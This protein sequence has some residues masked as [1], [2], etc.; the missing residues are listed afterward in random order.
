MSSSKWESSYYGKGNKIIDNHPY[1]NVPY[2]IDIETPQH[3]TSLWYYDKQKLLKM[4]L[5]DQ[6]SD[7]DVLVKNARIIKQ[8][9]AFSESNMIVLDKNSMEKAIDR[10]EGRELYPLYLEYK[11][12]IVQSKIL[13]KIRD[14]DL[15]FGSDIAE[16]LAKESLDKVHV[17]TRKTFDY[18]SGSSDRP[19]EVFITEKY[20]PL[21][22]N[23]KPKNNLSK[24]LYDEMISKCDINT[25]PGEIIHNHLRSGK[26]NTDLI[27][28][29]LCLNGNIFYKKDII[30]NIKPFEVVLLLD[31]S[32]SMGGYGKLGI[33]EHIATG[34]TKFI[35]HLG[36]SVQIFGHS[37]YDDPVLYSML[38]KGE[39][40]D[41]CSFRAITNRENYD[42]HIVEYLFKKI[43]KETDILLISISDGEPCGHG[44]GGPSAYSYL[45]EQVEK[46][47]REGTIVAGIGLNYN[48]KGLYQ[49][50]T[51]L[52]CGQIDSEIHKIPTL[53]NRIIASEYV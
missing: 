40:V 31:Y 24:Q 17:Y 14:L 51:D 45:K 36:K 44:Y 39:D 46:I 29:S 42:G 3:I 18:S 27:S 10:C 13:I 9:Y 7:L 25:S 16:K 53:I 47:K 21:L 52:D 15:N 2:E 12:L 26:L 33:Q 23:R 5:L 48:R 11:E 38:R 34:I 8:K 4:F 6:K 19:R 30:D 22:L 50:E 49:Y 43:K 35:N 20:I 32:G 37:G 1:I 28:Q 41:Y